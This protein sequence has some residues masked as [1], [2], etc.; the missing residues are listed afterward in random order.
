MDTSLKIIG[1]VH[2]KLKKIEDC[3]LQEAEQAP[4]AS[5]EIFAEFRKGIEDLTAG[6]E[7]V[8][9]TWLHQ[10]DRSVIRCVTRNQFDKPKIGVFST[11]SPDRPNPIG[12]HIAEVIAVENGMVHVSRL[13][14]LD[15]TPVLDI[16]P[17]L[18]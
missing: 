12:M 18:K 5:L 2:S 17:V 14:T 3:P 6:S 1:R 9:L 7:I 10:A 4:P 16:K 11:R 13:E 15:G 8:I